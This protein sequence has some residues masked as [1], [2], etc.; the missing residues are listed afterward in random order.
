MVVNDE[1]MQCRSNTILTYTDYWLIRLPARFIR[2]Q[3]SS[4]GRRVSHGEE[5]GSAQLGVEV[6][7]SME[8]DGTG[9]QE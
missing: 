4:F 8:P 1:V 2:R 5:R 6:A 3:A 7:Q 9:N